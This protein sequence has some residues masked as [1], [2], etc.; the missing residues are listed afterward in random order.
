MADNLRDQAKDI[1]DAASELEGAFGSYREAL[2]AQNKEL[3]AQV[4][5]I[6]EASSLYNQLDG[7]LKK[8]QNQEEGITRLTDKQLSDVRQKANEQVAEIQRR[9]QALADE[10]GLAQ[11][12][13]EQLERA[14]QRLA[15]AGKLTQAEQSLLLAKANNFDL[16][17]ESLALIEKEVAIREEAN[18]LLGITGGSLKAINGLL[19]QFASA[20]NLDAVEAKMSE[21][22]DE[23]ARGERSGNKLTVALSGAGEAVKGLAS[24][25]MDPA[26]IIGGIVSSFAKFEAQNRQVRQL[27]GQSATNFQNFSNSAI[28]AV[29]A[30][31]TIGSLSQE[32]GINVNAAFS[33]NTIMA[34]TELSELLGL[35]AQETAN[36]ALRAEVFGE[37]LGAAD[38][39]AEAIVQNF[40]KQGKGA[41]NVQQVLKGAGA[42]SNSLALSVKG[43][44]EGLLKAAANA[45][46]LGINLQQA[47]AI[48]DSLLDF[49]QS[50]SN[51]LEAE[52]LTGKSLN[53]EKARTAALN[54]DIAT[55]TEEIGN[56][57]EIMEAFSS[58][59]RIQQ[60][61]IAKSLG[62]SKDDVAKMIF[63]KQK[64]NQ[65]TDEQ[66]AKAA[67]INIEEAKRLSATESINKSIEQLT[68]AFAPILDQFAKII[69]SKAGMMAVKIIVAGLAAASVVKGITGLAGSFTELGSSIKGA[70]SGMGSFLKTAKGAGGGVKG[71][72]AGVKDALGIGGDAAKKASEGVSQVAD[73]SKGAAAG[74]AQQGQG[75]KDLLTG[76]GDGLKSMAGTKVLQGALNLIPAA[77]GFV[78][79]TAGAI[80]LA[81]IALAGNAA[82]V[83]LQ[84]LSTG[85]TVFANAMAAPTP[86]GPVGLVAPVALA[87]LGAAMIPFAYALSVAAPA[88]EAIGTVIHAVFT[89]IGVIITSVAEGFV[90]LMDALTLEKTQML[91]IMGIGLMSLAAGVVALG[92]SAVLALSA[93]ATL[94]LLGLSM[95]PLSI[96][97]EKMAEAD[98]AGLVQ[99]LVT[100]AGIAP[101]MGS[102]AASLFGV[103]G[104]LGAMAVAGIAA[105][106]IVTAL[107]GLGT[108]ATGIAGVFGG[109]EEETTE[110][111]GANNA[112]LEAKLDE[113][114]KNMTTLITTVKEG[115]VINIDGNKAGTFF[116]MGASKMA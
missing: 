22:A 103:A 102:L 46:R 20:F 85:L 23:I 114:N 31:K 94:T 100:F 76:L 107:A 71:I 61:A 112:N 40:A 36:M 89:G 57:T 58:G 1:R 45:Q 34:A 67:G 70:M 24:T 39:Q 54:N 95:I 53:L 48:A 79:M 30:V 83:G 50:I 52:L 75:I 88:I 28:S 110:A 42:A 49:E 73:A 19:G 84:G 108:V 35:S 10:R 47:E 32:I 17:E 69:S 115:G 11:L 87:L 18:R 81:A 15:N 90:M 72:R 13:E 26:V 91:P 93:A 64:E 43:G 7:Q 14:V 63:L 60:D 37:D 78:A 55:L 62:M 4:S 77:L 12:S 8:L 29:D 80:G 6:K 27:T 2:R 109:G 33:S 3:G 113:L 106:P 68:A 25:L 111:G 5:N 86:L 9:A 16:E 82:G 92:A 51:E 41:L 74:G 66:A 59:N 101:A 105:L 44:Q 96:G 98:T 56:N 38:D 116:A 21:V 97:F 104:G 65:L 99:S